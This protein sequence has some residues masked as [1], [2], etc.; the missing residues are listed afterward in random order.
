MACR[1]VG[2][3]A[4][5]NPKH[6]LSTRDVDASY[7]YRVNLEII[8]WWY[9]W[10]L[11]NYICRA[12]L[13]RCTVSTVYLNVVIVLSIRENE[14][15]YDSHEHGVILHMCRKNVSHTYQQCLHLYYQYEEWCIPPLLLVQLRHALVY[16]IKPVCIKPHHYD[17]TLNIPLANRINRTINRS[18]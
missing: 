8:H 4:W 15:K 18:L 1:E 9:F 7:L 11:K 10:Y 3:L 2:F 17:I 14:I 13:H 5:E 16:V 6:T 12:R